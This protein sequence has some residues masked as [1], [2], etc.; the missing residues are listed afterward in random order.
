MANTTKTVSQGNW[1]KEENQASWRQ[2]AI[3]LSK[4]R[5]KLEK[6]RGVTLHRVD[7]RTVIIKFN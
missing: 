6:E 2:T 5:A 3:K 7:S 1:V 4:E